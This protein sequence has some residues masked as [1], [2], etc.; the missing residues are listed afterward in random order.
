MIFYSLLGCASSGNRV[1]HDSDKLDLT[2]ITTVYAYQ[3]QQE[4]LQH[5]HTSASE[6]YFSVLEEQFDEHGINLIQGD[7]LNTKYSDIKE[8]NPAIIQE[9]ADLIILCIL[10]ASSVLGLTSDYKADYKFLDS[11]SG[12]LL[13]ET[14]MIS[15]TTV[16]IPSDESKMRSAFKKGIMKFK[17]QH[18]LNLSLIHI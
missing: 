12:T 2:T 15:T 5:N 18:L 8:Y 17:E 13:Y 10:R 11:K 6:V 16:G 7:I 9:D 1:L 4:N 3:P 14:K